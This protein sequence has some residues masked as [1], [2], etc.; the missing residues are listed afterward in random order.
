MDFSEVIG[1][2]ETKQQLLQL[3]QSNRVPH[4]LLFCGPR[5]SGKM[6]LA[7]A[8]ASYLLTQ[9]SMSPE[10][11]KAMLRNW[12]HPDL[13]FTFPT[14]KLPGMSSEHQP[15]SSDFAKEWHELVMKGAYFTLK[16]W[17]ST[18]GATTQQAIITG[19]ESDELSRVLSL[20]SSQGGYKVSVIWL[21]ERM[22]L[23]SANKL[24]KLLEEPSERTLFLMISEEPEKL[25]ETIISRTQR[26]DVKRISDD[27]IEQALRERRGL[28]AETARR[29]A[30]VA[31]GNWLKALE[32]LTTENEN[33][34]FLKMFQSLMR[35][36]YMRDVSEL[37]N[38]SETAAD[39]GREKQR[40]MLL[41][42]QLQIRENFIYNFKNPDLNY[43]TAEEENFAKRFAR[44]INEENVIEINE[45]YGNSYRD[46]G[47]N[48]NAKVVFYDMAL[49]MIVLLLR[50]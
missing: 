40:R 12:E 20:K 43:M 39:Y 8:F 2:E 48:A 28:D 50:K 49:K 24:L 18:M 5:G 9:S 30:R 13:H 22:N 7:M 3:A 27:A 45:L 38:W 21:P 35:L 23:T 11:S 6:A 25:L 36:C 26:I 32:L 15:L 41:Y 31:H 1:Q 44:F 42:F 37:K 17:M 19:A 46:L 10:N 29:L 47:Q 4:A 16:H 34:E 33:M 14:I